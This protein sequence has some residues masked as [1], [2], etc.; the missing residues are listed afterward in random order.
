MS[1]DR[2]VST[3]ALQK[4][5]KINKNKKWFSLAQIQGVG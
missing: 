2:T 3:R 5:L 1:E 4:I